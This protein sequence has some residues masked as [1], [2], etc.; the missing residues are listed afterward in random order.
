[1]AT[2]AQDIETRQGPEGNPPP[3]QAAFALFGILSGSW[4][5]QVLMVGTELGLADA[6]LDGP[7][8]VEELAE[9]TGT[10]APSLVRIVRAL[11]SL[12]IL[13]EQM[14]GQ[15][16][17]T[18]LSLHLC[19]DSPGSLRE[20]LLFFH[21]DW[22]W[23]IWNELLYSVKTGQS[24]MRHAHGMGIWEYVDR[25]PDDLRMLNTGTDQFSTLITP[26]ILAAYDF[27]VFRS[28]TDVG[29]GF[30]NFLCLLAENNPSFHGTLFDRP[31]VIEEAKKIYAGTPFESRL[32]MAPGNFFEELPAG[33]DAY[34]YKFVI[35]DWGDDYVRQML[36]ACR[37]AIP[38]HGKLLIAEFVLT[39]KPDP[40]S[41]LMSVV[42]FLGFDGGH[43]RTREEFR[44]LLKE[45]GFTL[46]RVL[47]T[48]SSLS[49]IEGVPD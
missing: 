4:A 47:P 31:S 27:S 7:K 11:V 1:M 39:E 46:T 14:P 10:H 2:Q 36:T 40:I 8:T 29:G 24:A 44:T 13:G 41:A 34:F 49:L 25:H 26:T 22:A 12:G 30:G 48:A 17:N 42:T 15:Y 45:C 9:A 5:A 28:L 6:L 37:R 35:N 23:S 43:G 32:T 33:R 20:F 16:S 18:P 38:G 19:K 21:R 3:G